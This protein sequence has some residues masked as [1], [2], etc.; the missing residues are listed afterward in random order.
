MNHYESLNEKK[1]GVLFFFPSYA[2]MVQCHKAWN[3]GFKESGRNIYLESQDKKL[4]KDLLKCYISDCINKEK[5]PILF[6]VCRAKF[7]EGHDFKDDLCRNM[8]II[9]I[10]NLASTPK[11]I[12]YAL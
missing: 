6:G 12:F 7:A 1:G 11:L 4:N 8:A 2:A 3:A 10:P 9:G 5:G